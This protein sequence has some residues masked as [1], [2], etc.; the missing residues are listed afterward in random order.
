[1]TFEYVSSDGSVRRIST[2][3]MGLDALLYGG[4]PQRNQVMLAGDAGTGK[5]LMSFEMLYR[6]AN[7]NIPSCYI[8]LEESRS[9]LIENIRGAY[10]YFTDLDDL[11][12]N[13]VINIH[14]EQAINAFSSREA[15]QAFVAGLNKAIKS[16]NSQVV[17]LDSITTLRPIAED[18]RVFTRSVNTLIENFRNLGVTSII[19]METQSDIMDESIGLFGTFM[20]DGIIKLTSEQ[21]KGNTQYNVSVIK[22]RRSNHRRASPP[23]E[24]TSKGFTVFNP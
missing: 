21:V 1:M 14:E 20:F 19:T 16:N 4:I 17:V 24:I 23:Y 13:N 10:T 7:V 22:M 6:N 15:F 12:Q 3:I 2:G 8:T 11:I 5:T 18:D 9:S